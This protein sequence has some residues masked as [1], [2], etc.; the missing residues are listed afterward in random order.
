MTLLVRVF[1]KGGGGLESKRKDSRG[2]G[3]PY[4]LSCLYLEGWESGDVA[5][6]GLFPGIGGFFLLGL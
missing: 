2:K 4:Y 1:I 6:V 3:P 5:L